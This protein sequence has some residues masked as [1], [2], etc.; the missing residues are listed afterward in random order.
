[1]FIQNFFNLLFLFFF[2][3]FWNCF[4]SNLLWI[5]SFL[6]K[7]SLKKIIY[8]FWLNLQLQLLLCIVWLLKCQTKFSCSSSNQCRNTKR[9]KKIQ[10]CLVYLYWKNSMIYYIF[11]STQ[12]DCLV[13]LRNKIIRILKRFFFRHYNFLL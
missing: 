6:T 5:Y 7:F 10:N 1:M 4:T 11:E 13:H 9:Q 8:K 3:V 2:D 12:N